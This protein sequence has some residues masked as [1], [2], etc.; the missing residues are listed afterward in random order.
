[1]TRR[2]ASVSTRTSRPRSYDSVALEGS[3]CDKRAAAAARGAFRNRLTLTT[4]TQA[5]N[6][7]QSTRAT[8]TL[9]RALVRSAASDDRPIIGGPP[10]VPM[11]TKSRTKATTSIAARELIPAG[12]TSMPVTAIARHAGVAVQTIYDISATRRMIAATPSF[13]GEAWP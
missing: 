4:A 6:A 5:M 13:W 11:I 9:S 2:T 10:V 3:G 12:G 8:T 7:R 1:M